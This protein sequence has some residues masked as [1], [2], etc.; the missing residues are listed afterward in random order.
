MEFPEGLTIAYG[1]F[2]LEK[3]LRGASRDGLWLARDLKMQG[4]HVWVT[5]RQAKSTA[6]RTKMLTFCAHGVPLPIYVGPPDLYAPEGEKVRDAHLCVVDEIPD[7]VDLSQAGR[8]AARQ[9]IELGVELCSL[10]ATWATASDGVVL[11][12]LRP[13]TIFVS[14]V[15]HRFVGATPSPY[16][17]LGN[18]NEYSAYPRVAFDPPG[19]GHYILDVCDG[20][21]TVALLVW[22][23]LTGVQP[24]VIDSTDHERNE[25][26]DRRIPFDG[27]LPLGKLLE[28]ALVADRD[29]R[30][31]LDEFRDGLA[32]LA[33]K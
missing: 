27:P 29:A 25:L 8:L 9:S 26:E 5:I 10:L 22:W 31:S 4:R 18:Q 32:A 21:F 2:R 15:D 16:Y 24:Y 30:I 13:E 20:V 6:Q 14:P 3:L 33:T 17:L 1:R 19:M 28:R 11:R 23:A 12:G 7:G